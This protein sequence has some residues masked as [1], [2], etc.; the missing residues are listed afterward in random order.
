MRIS[1]LVLPPDLMQSSNTLNLF[2]LH[3]FIK[4][5]EYNRHLKRM[6]HHYEIKRK[7]LINEL[8]NHFGEKIKIEDIPAGLHFLA[9][10]RTD[11]TYEII[12][13][14]PKQKN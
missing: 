5:G 4:S 7:I 8:I 6:N 9:Y 3:Y 2:T 11:R 14:N 12:I 1:Y 10:F 13:E